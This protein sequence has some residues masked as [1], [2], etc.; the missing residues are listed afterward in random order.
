[1]L[2]SASQDRTSPLSSSL[3]L[4]PRAGSWHPL[5]PPLSIPSY[6]LHFHIPITLFS[7]LIL[8][9]LRII[10]LVLFYQTLL[11]DHLSLSLVYLT[12]SSPSPFPP[13]CPSIYYP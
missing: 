1:M 6:P 8:T 3:V 7:L 5:P 11:L 10:F 4:C 13:S 9:I 12:V 2:R